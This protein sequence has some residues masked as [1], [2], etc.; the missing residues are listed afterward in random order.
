M[1]YHGQ[2]KSIGLMFYAPKTLVDNEI[3]ANLIALPSAWTMI[4]GPLPFLWYWSFFFY[5]SSPEN[6][7]VWQASD[8]KKHVFGSKHLKVELELSI[9]EYIAHFE[10]RQCERYPTSIQIYH[11][12]NGKAYLNCLDLAALHTQ[13]VF[14]A[15]RPPNA[16]STKSLAYSC[17]VPR[18]QERKEVPWVTEFKKWMLKE[19]LFADTEPLQLRLT[20]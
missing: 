8:D 13:I 10:V 1:D 7:D 3:C 15:R 4:L 6:N 16:L 20:M 14:L 19:F 5:D 9:H 12:N 2:A 18:L 11:L 17:S